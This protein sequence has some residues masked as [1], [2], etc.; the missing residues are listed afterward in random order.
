M[1]HLTRERE[2]TMSV[3]FRQLGLDKLSVDERLDLIDDLWESI[4]GDQPAGE[5][6]IPEDHRRELERRIA[7]A[8]ANPDAG[9]P[10]AEWKAKLAA[11]F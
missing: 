3:L 8:D 4:E 7:D 2:V 6:V 9:I 1:I 11:D 5:F 10:F